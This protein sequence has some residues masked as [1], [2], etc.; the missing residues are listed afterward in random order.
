LAPNVKN[1]KRNIANLYSINLFQASDARFS[2]PK[3]DFVQSL[4]QLK[5]TGLVDSE[6]NNVICVVTYTL[7]LAHPRAKF[8]EKMEK[9]KEVL[10]KVL[11]E[12]LGTDVPVVFVENEIED[13]QKCDDWTL[14][15]G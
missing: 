3:S 10:T 4:Q 8:V 1:L 12:H 11:H 9:K 14:L 5:K 15:P 13:L 7:N 6:T 2:G